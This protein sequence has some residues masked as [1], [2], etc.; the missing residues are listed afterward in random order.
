MPGYVIKGFGFNLSDEPFMSQEMKNHYKNYGWKFGDALHCRVRAIWD[1]QMLFIT[2]KKIDESVNSAHHNLV[3]C[4]I[5]DYSNKGLTKEEGRLFWR[6]LGEKQWN[7]IQLNQTEDPNHFFAEIP[8][9]ES[10][11]TIE[12]YV[13][14]VSKSGRKETQPR[15]AP[16]WAYR[17][18]IK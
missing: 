18:I 4:T 7:S 17:F 10:N 8:F 9:H 5:I 13:S 12:Y 15:T 16:Q 11:N 1:P 14:A 6:L 3:F 2:A